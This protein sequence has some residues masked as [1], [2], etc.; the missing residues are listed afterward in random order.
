MTKL[1]DAIE[2]AFHELGAFQ[3][4][5]SGNPHNDARMTANI[6]IGVQ[7]F[8][9][10]SHAAANFVPDLKHDLEQALAAEIE[11]RKIALRMESEGLVVSLREIGFFASGSATLKPGSEASI[12]R[13]AAILRDRRVSMRV[14]GHTDDVP[15]HTSQFTSNWELSTARATEMI[16]LLIARYGFLPGRLSAAGYGEFHPLASNHSAEGR[17]QNRRLDL[18]ILADSSPRPNNLMRSLDDVQLVSGGPR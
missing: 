8:S 10:S 12:A 16:K 15:I 4:S 3:A 13:I 2:G 9:D 11:D 18:V 6:A 17:R 14:E 5:N 7:D 1:A